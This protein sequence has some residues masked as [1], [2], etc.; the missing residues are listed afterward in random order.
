MVTERNAIDEKLV[1]FVVRTG[2]PEFERRNLDAR[3]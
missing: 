1:T 3:R 2:T